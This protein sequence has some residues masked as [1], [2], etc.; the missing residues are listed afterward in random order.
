MSGQ[1]PKSQARGLGSEILRLALQPAAIAYGLGAYLRLSAY[2][3]RILKQAETSV[4]VISVGNITCGGTGKTPV[5]ID[6]ARRLRQAGYKPA[7]L[8]RG[9]KRQSSAPYVVVS[10][11]TTILA[12]CPDAGDEPYLI[13]TKCPGVVVIV[14][15]KRKVTAQIAVEKHGCD[16]ILLDDGFQHLGIA[17]D[18]DIVLVDYNDDPEKDAVLPAGR[19]REP[20][21]ALARAS[22]ILITKVPVNPDKSYLEK[23]GNFLHK[24]SPGASIGLVRFES[25]FLIGLNQEV[26]QGNRTSAWPDRTSTAPDRTSTAPDRTSTAP[27]RTSTATDRTS[28]ATDR[29]STATDR[30]SAAPDLSLAATA[31]SFGL[32]EQE[33]QSIAGKRVLAFCAL[34]R[35]Q[36]FFQSL[37]N[38]NVTVVGTHS[39]PDHHWYTKKDLQKL[40]EEGERLSCDLLLTTEKDLVKLL[41][42]KEMLRQPILA[43]TLTTSWVGGR[44]NY[45][46]ELLAAKT[47]CG[48]NPL[49]EPEQKAL[50][51]Q[52]NFAISGQGASSLASPNG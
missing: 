18:L 31:A 34:A 20:V 16:V 38:F 35:P 41:E 5:A 51:Q 44:P 29:T 3:R 19:L 10:D 11:G 14:G 1:K 40:Q 37:T 50:P 24:H 32:A 49:A 8:S 28:T 22:A 25:E 47:A 23:L 45:L 43:P 13:A 15:A 7:V 26:L 12:S 27:D 2:A 30:T 39:F 48:N 33:I 9:Y 21:A 46:S 6:I 4:P 17:R 36:A 42:F 52:P